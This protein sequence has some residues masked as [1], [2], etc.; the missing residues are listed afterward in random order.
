MAA[1]SG[2]WG[3]HLF[4]TSTWKAAPPLPL[5]GGRPLLRSAT[6]S[7]D[8]RL[9]AVVVNQFTVQLIDLQTFE[10]KG[11]LRPPG[12]VMMRGLSFSPDGSHLTAVGP[13]ARVAVWDLRKIRQQLE[14][15]GVSW[16]VP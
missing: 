2:G 15:F 1:I 16:N 14:T 8:G 11:T 9:L 10:S 4:E 6:F 7:P 3:F 5:P 12:D 13:E